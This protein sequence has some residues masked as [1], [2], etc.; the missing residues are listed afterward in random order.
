MGHQTRPSGYR[1]VDDKAYVDEV[2]RLRLVGMRLPFGGESVTSE[3]RRNSWPSKTVPPRTRTA[4]DLRPGRAGPRRTGEVHQQRHP[5]RCHP[6]RP[7]RGQFPHR[8]ERPRRVHGE[9]PADRA[10]GGASGRRRRC[11]PHAPSSAGV[12]AINARLPPLVARAARLGR[13]APG[14]FL[15]AVRSEPRDRGQH[16]YQGQ[17]QRQRSSG[18]TLRA[19]V[20]GHAGGRRRSR[21]HI[22]AVVTDSP[23]DGMMR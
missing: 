6:R 8:R 19:R 23:T 13:G 16:H 9:V 7:L 20:G 21:E 4:P 2:E 17:E 11:M 14:T 22:T 15:P 1:V 3:V 5:R 18:R 12:P 10:A